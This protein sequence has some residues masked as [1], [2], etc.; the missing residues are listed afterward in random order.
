M[1][2][3]RVRLVLVSD[4]ERTAKRAARETRVAFGDWQTPQRLAHEVLGVVGR[5]LRRP[6]SILE[7]TCG[8]GAFLG[9]AVAAF[10]TATALGFDVCAEHVASARE[11]LA[12]SATIELADF[13]EVP[14]ERVLDPLADPLLIIGN[15]PWV[16]NSTLGTLDASNLPRKT[17][18]KRHAGLD[19]MTGKSN[20]D[21]SE[22]MLI[23]L[24][25][26]VRERRFTMA[27]LCKASV[28]RRLMQHVA[29]MGWRVDG[30]VRA[31]D[32]RAHF[33]AAVDAVLLHVW[34]GRSRA[35]SGG[36]DG[37]RWAVYTSLSET[38]PTRTMGVVDGRTL[39]DVDAYES[40]RTLEG[41][42]EIEWRSGVK[43]DCANVMELVATGEGWTNG[44]G[45][46]VELESSHVY[47]LL[48]GS[49]IANG[50]LVPRRHVI[51]TQRSLG[52]DTGMFRESAPL[53]WKYLHDHREQL[54]GRKSSI[55]ANQFEF[56]I[57]GIG[58]YS[59]APYKVAI[60]GLYKRLV[61]SVIRPYDGQPVM[62]DDTAYFLPFDTEQAAE[63]AALALSSP[64]AQAFFQ[65]RV[66]WDAKRPINKALL[67]SLSLEA[68]LS[69]K[70]AVPEQSIAGP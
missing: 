32:A 35:S 29:E 67:Q 63:A 12:N 18:F 13:F 68:L 66:F 30:E 50:R 11:L 36:S 53:L 17:N 62:V 42:S 5:R 38:V 4:P 31:I 60:C 55:Y 54:D 20:F 48:K 47:P 23:R 43:H 27:M 51:I 10:P 34:S 52:E 3:P 33:S 59:F 14:W 2:S 1:A 8:Q 70:F 64:P 16:T 40:T 37:V 65:A 24:L 39:S 41:E 26:L 69:A 49:D 7:P 9:A 19:A 58:D 22:W 28:A 45:Q 44:A 61:F 25:E 56:S 21:I 57:F 46:T 6:R 15:P